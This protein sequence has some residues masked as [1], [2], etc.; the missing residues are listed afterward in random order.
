M[1]KYFFNIPLYRFSKE[2]FMLKVD[3]VRKKNL[4][5]T[6]IHNN[7]TSSYFDEKMVYNWEFNEIV[8]YLRLYHQLNILQVDYWSYEHKRK[9]WQFGIKKRKF[10]FNRTMTQILLD[11][12]NMSSELITQTIVNRL[13]NYQEGH[14]EIGKYYIDFQSFN[15]VGNAL[16][17]NKIK[18]SSNH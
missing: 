2:D 15:Q 8:G 11:Y 1:E 13:I 5:F 10:Q 6:V 3:E 16:D 17:W 4:A 12:D 9:D 7:D 18:T 14:P